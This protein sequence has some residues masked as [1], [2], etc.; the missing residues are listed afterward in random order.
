MTDPSFLGLRHALEE[1]DSRVRLENEVP[2]ATPFV[3]GA[4]FGGGFLDGQIIHFSRNL[5]CI[6]GGRGT[7]KSTTFEAIRCLVGAETEAEMVDSGW[8]P[9]FGQ[10]SYP[11]LER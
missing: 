9:K 11:V 4:A 7:G 10:T 5:N 3:L 1:C 2:E 6:I 8:T